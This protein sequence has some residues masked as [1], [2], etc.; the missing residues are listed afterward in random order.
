MAGSGLSFLDGLTGQLTRQLSPDVLR[1]E[2]AASVTQV[3]AF[4]VVWT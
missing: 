1:Q 3:T 4:N 2:F